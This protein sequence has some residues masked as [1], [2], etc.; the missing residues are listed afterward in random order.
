M[1]EGMLEREVTVHDLSCRYKKMQGAHRKKNDPPT[2][3]HHLN[4]AITNRTKIRAEKAV[5]DLGTLQQPEAGTD[6]GGASAS[7]L[8]VDMS[9]VER[10]KKNGGGTGANHKSSIVSDKTS[11]NIFAPA[12]GPKAWREAGNALIA[13]ADAYNENAE[14]STSPIKVSD[15]V[16]LITSKQQFNNHVAKTVRKKAKAATAEDT[17]DKLAKSGAVRKTTRKGY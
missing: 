3:A 4:D 1:L 2:K 12:S 11:I 9:N 15:Q 14:P 17:R 5:M 10:T 8:L 13:A 6:L 7:T 16:S